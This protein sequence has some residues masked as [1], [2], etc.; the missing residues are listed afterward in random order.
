MSKYLYGSLEACSIRI[1]D[2]IHHYQFLFVTIFHRLSLALV[3]QTLIVCSRLVL[4]RLSGYRFALREVRMT[5]TNIKNLFI[6]DASDMP[7]RRFD[8]DWLRVIAFGF[9]IFYHIGM[10]YVANWGF[11]IKSGYLSAELENLML[12]VNP[13]RMPLLWLISGIAIRFILAKVSLGRF[14][15]LRSYRLLLPLLFGVLVIVPPQLYY[16]MT[17]KGDISIGYW[18]FYQAFFDLDHPM[19]DK[20]NYGIWPHMDVNHLWYL[21]ELWTFSLYLVFL[22]PILHSK[23]VTQTVNWIARQNGILAIT[24]FALPVLLVDMLFYIEENRK[25]MGFLFLVYGYL[26]G[27]NPVIWQRL[28][29]NFRSLLIAAIIAYIVLLLGYNLLYLE[30]NETSPGW[31]RHVID[32][33]YGANRVFWLFTILGLSYKLLNRPSTRLK[34]FSEAVYPY[35]ILHQSIIVVVGFELSQLVLGP[36]VEPVLVILATFTGCALGF[37]IIRRV[38]FLRPLF[39]L[40]LKASFPWGIQYVARGVAAVLVIPIALEILI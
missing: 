1:W 2:I 18:E 39:G 19:F 23:P 38:E 26:L 34:Y 4:K 35:Y 10:M 24:L 33:V 9:L 12:L 6:P 14:V 7:A 21:R 11:H 36:V 8:L 3:N 17:F 29:N 22:L 27:W 32:L 16:E 40:K 13:W 25:L 37:E 28:K 20:Y 31:H 5:F 30:L 15:V